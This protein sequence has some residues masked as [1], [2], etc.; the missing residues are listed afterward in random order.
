MLL[1][2]VCGMRI[3]VENVVRDVG[4]G[5]AANA[6]VGGV[7]TRVSVDLTRDGS[8]RRWGHNR[9][10]GVFVVV[11]LECLSCH[12]CLVSEQ[13][14]FPSPTPP[15]LVLAPFSRVRRGF[16]FGQVIQPSKSLVSI[17][18]RVAGKYK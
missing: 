12:L 6:C 9:T 13:P 3:G 4:K 15:F 17:T 1:Y 8:A 7:V 11:A 14:S 16:F 18:E 2:L 5:V 10:G